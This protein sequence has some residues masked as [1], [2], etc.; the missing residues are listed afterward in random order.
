MWGRLAPA[1]GV[2]PGDEPTL[3]EVAA[4]DA[5]Q[6]GINFTVDSQRKREQASDETRDGVRKWALAPYRALESIRLQAV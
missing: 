6:P 1:L 3:R 4:F 2:Q 5:K